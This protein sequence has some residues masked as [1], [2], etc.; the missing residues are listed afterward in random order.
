[1]GDTGVTEMIPDQ[2]IRHVS[3]SNLGGHSKGG[4]PWVCPTGRMEHREDPEID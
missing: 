4:R 3:N 1:M 2:R